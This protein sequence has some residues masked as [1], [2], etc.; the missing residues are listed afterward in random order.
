MRHLVRSQRL[1]G[2]FT[3]RLRRAAARFTA[4]S[5]DVGYAEEGS[6]AFEIEVREMSVRSRHRWLTDDLSNGR[7]QLREPMLSHRRA[8][9]GG[10]TTERGT[11]DEVRTRV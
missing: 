4:Q 8:G 10:R 1:A 2:A 6:G 5:R 3:R 11:P 9:L 7:T